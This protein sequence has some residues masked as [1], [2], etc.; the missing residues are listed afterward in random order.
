MSIYR[1]LGPRRAQPSRGIWEPPIIQDRARSALQLEPRCSSRQS[2]SLRHSEFS[3]NLS[4]SRTL[5]VVFNEG[6]EEIPVY[7]YRDSR[8]RS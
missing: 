1:V 6:L 2:S 3:R 7:L 5:P 4:G 8:K